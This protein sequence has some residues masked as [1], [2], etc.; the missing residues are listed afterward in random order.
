MKIMKIW[1]IAFATLATFSL[2]RRMVQ[3][4]GSVSVSWKSRA[5]PTSVATS[6]NCW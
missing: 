6:T 5:S 1:R 4:I 2:A 3:P